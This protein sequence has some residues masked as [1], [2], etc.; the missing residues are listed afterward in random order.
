M[1]ELKDWLSIDKVSGEGNDVITLTAS[2]LE[3]VGERNASIKI[4][5]A[6]KSVYLNLKQRKLDAPVNPDD[7]L[8]NELWVKSADGSQVTPYSSS[9]SYKVSKTR[10]TSDGWTLYTLKEPLTEIDGLAFYQTKIQEV[11]MPKTVT[12]IGRYAFADCKLESLDIPDSVTTIGERAFEDNRITTLKIGSGVSGIDSLMFSSCNHITSIVVS[13]NNETYDSRNNSN[14]II[15]TATNKLI[16]GCCNTV[17]PDTVTIIGDRAFSESVINLGYNDTAPL[18]YIVIPNSVTT[19]E[20]YA[21]ANCDGLTEITIPD[22]VTSIGV[23]AF[24]NCRN[25]V[26]INLGNG[27]TSIGDTV[28]GWCKLTSINIPDS[29][30]T[31]DD[32]AFKYCENLESVYIGSGVSDFTGKAFS[33]TDNLSSIVVSPNNTKYHS[34]DNCVIETETNELILGCK[35]SVIPNTVKEIN[36]G[37]FYGCQMTSI[38][39]PNSVTR[40]NG[41][42][43]YGCSQLT[44]LVI[45]DSVTYIGLQAFSGCSGLT[46]VTFGSKVSTIEY[47]AF[48]SCK[49]LERIICK[50]KAA[51]INSTTFK[52]V[53]TGGVLEYPKSYSYSSW[54]STSSY[55]LGYYGWTGVTY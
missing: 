44:S 22:S 53:K 13:E 48:N 46:T 7:I 20:E 16:L 34:I 43:F 17:I 50:G 12:T 38:D 45:P 18:K 10:L 40:I 47:S 1:A 28:F 26:S 21:F 25:L 15:E 52:Y 55:Y 35:N 9:F 4:S 19:I 6:T 37:A 42:S 23:C 41:N 51:Y 29:V 32:D 33:N 24:Y 27:L 30:T 31:I 11:V 49:N 2:L 5:T 36:Y 8:D 3:E 54:L 39:I 14:C